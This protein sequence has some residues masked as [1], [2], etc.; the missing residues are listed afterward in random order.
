[1]KWTVL[2][3]LVLPAWPAPCS[4]TAGS[5]GEEGLCHEQYGALGTDLLLHCDMATRVDWR[6]NGTQVAASEDAVA[7][8][9]GQLWLRNASLA[10]EGEYSC[11]QPGTG[12]TLRRI[13]LQ[14]GLPPEKPAVECWAVSYPQTVNCTWK[15][16]PEPGLE[17][18]FITTYRHGLGAQESKCVQPGA[19]A[20]SCTIS[21]I[22]LFSITPYV[23]NVTAV[24]PLGAAMTLFP[25][26]AEQIIRP[27]PPEGLRVSPIPG[28]SKKLLLEWQPP[29]SW[30]FPQ[31]F[32]L[33][34][35]I[36]Y[37]REGAKSDRTIGPYEQTS[38]I[39]TGIRPRAIHHVQ[40]AA[41]D[42]T[43]YGEYSAWSP[44]VSGTP[45]MQQ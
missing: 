28:E 3:A 25:F 22:Q 17:T 15:L 33:K 23:L 30:P 14:V 45:W 8:D 27:D 41:K 32:P 40:V 2:L 20:S 11:H 19:G 35:L 21:D 36:R 42:F 13:R 7:R 10:Q 38:F 44:R 34:Y 31:Y 16:Q 43:D 9:K 18:D 29:S 6:V 26:I 39:L 5:D 12:K 4:S 24:N 37:A 1:M